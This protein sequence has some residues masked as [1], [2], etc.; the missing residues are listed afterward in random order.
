MH[1]FRVNSRSTEAAGCPTLSKTNTVFQGFFAEPAV[2]MEHIHKNM[3]AAYTR[4]AADRPAA[5]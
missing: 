2:C 3:R 1:I 4:P 5:I